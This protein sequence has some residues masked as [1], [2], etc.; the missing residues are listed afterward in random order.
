MVI[1]GFD[2]IVIILFSMISIG[3]YV[4]IWEKF[5]R[6][7]RPLTPP[8][9]EQHSF[10]SLFIRLRYAILK[11]NGI[12]IP[13][14]AVF[15]LNTTTRIWECPALGDHCSLT[16][17]DAAYLPTSHI[18]R[19]T[20]EIFF[21][22]ELQLLAERLS[23]LSSQGRRQL[24][25]SQSIEPGGTPLSKGPAPEPEVVIRSRYDR[26]LDDDLV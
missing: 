20:A 5:I 7:P 3:L 21:S 12:A 18:E 10:E 13:S 26:I 19:V 14:G 15:R 16:E 22:Y 6:P 25:H 9:L 17:M 23:N 4:R 8:K 1:P 2:Y 11:P 24:I